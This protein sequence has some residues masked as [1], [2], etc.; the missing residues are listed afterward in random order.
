MLGGADY[1]REG[2]HLAKAAKRYDA[3]LSS[4]HSGT[5]EKAQHW[6]KITHAQIN[7]WW[8][9]FGENH[10]VFRW[11]PLYPLRCLLVLLFLVALLLLSPFFLSVLPEV[12]ASLFQPPFAG[13]ATIIR[14][15]AL[16][17]DA[18]VTLFAAS[19]QSNSRLARELLSGDRR[20]FQVRSTNL[21]SVP[22]G[23]ASTAFKGL[24]K[25]SGVDAVG[26]FTALSNLFRYLTTWRVETDLAYFP[27]TE[28]ASEPARMEA[29]STLRWAWL[30]EPPIT[31]AREV[32]NAQDV[33]ALAFAVAARILGRY[34]VST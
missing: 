29:T 23:V 30:S 24:P 6:S 19:L 2:G 4:C 20:H 18:P 12:Y 25:I 28:N 31:V 27:S 8:W 32:R 11:V 7:S 22:S 1:E 5:K 17:K 14:P 13:A 21:L 15:T 3:L 16:S 34:F 26:T 10:P 33:D 9:Q